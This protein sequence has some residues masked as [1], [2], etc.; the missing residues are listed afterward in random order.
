MLFLHNLIN[1]EIQSKKWSSSKCFLLTIFIFVV[2]G[3]EDWADCREDD[4]EMNFFNPEPGWF[5]MDAAEN[6]SG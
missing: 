3:R 6:D 5:F 1:P 4:E 2:V